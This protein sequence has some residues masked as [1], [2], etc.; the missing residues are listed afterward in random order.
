MWSKTCWSKV[1]QQLMKSKALD[2][3][4]SGD[5]L[6]NYIQHITLTLMICHRRPRTKCGFPLARSWASMLTILQPILRLELRAIVKFSSFLYTVK[7]FLFKAR[8]SIVSGHEWFITLLKSDSIMLI[9]H[10]SYE[11]KYKNENTP[12]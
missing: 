8:G 9:K 3:H 1:H 11:K 6:L 7:F 2:K 5:E 10:V 12:N 4:W